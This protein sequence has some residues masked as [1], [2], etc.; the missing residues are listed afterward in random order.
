MAKT[1][2]LVRQRTERQHA[3]PQNGGGLVPVVFGYIGDVWL[4]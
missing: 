4:V 2:D 1:R 3:P